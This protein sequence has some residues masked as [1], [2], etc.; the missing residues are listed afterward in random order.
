MEASERKDYQ[1]VGCNLNGT[2]AFF[3]RKDLLGNRF[4]VSSD[5]MEYYHPPR[6]YLF[7]GYGL[8]AG[9]VPDPRMGR[10]W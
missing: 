10:C 6:Y 4:L 5:L 7:E 9:H 2:N 3:V 8:M 1:L